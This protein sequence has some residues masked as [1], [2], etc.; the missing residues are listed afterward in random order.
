M[1]Y[2]LTLGTVADL[3]ILEGSILLFV[4]PKCLKLQMG[5]KR[6]RY[7]WVINENF[8]NDTTRASTM[9]L[10]CKNS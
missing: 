9:E 8:K 2:A 5:M 3:F 6:D 7:W 10:F 1:L 4:I